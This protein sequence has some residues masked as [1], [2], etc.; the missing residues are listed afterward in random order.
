M[1]A[2]LQDIVTPRYDADQVLPPLLQPG[3]DAAT[4]IY[5]GTMVMVK[6]NGYAAPAAAGVAGS[7]GSVIGICN[8]QKINTT[9]AGYGSAGAL[10]VE[11]DR[12]AFW[13]NLNADS[14]VTIANFGA[15]V[16]A[17]DDNTVSLSDG[18][19]TRPLAGYLLSIPTT[20]GIPGL[21]NGTA[22]LKVAVQ[23]GMPSPWAAVSEQQSLSTLGKA[24]AVV[25]AIDAY[26]GS[27]TNVLTETTASSGFGTQDGVTV[28]VGDIVFLQ[29]GTANL[30][31]AKDSGPWQITT[32]GSASV[33]WVL[34]RP[35]WFS[36]GATVPPGYV[37]ELGGE[38][39]M[40]GGTSWK[41]FAAVGSAVVGTN[42]PEFYVGRVTQEVTLSSGVGHLSQTGAHSNNVGIYSATASQVVVT[43]TGTGGTTGT[44]SYGLGAALTPGYIG[45]SVATLWAFATAMAHNTSGE[46]GVLLAT[47]INW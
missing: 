45:T 19:G 30:S 35:D 11:V 8:K 18:G 34:T 43:Y 24:R 25:T 41:S 44:V 26:G 40:W 22:S 9:A 37:I 17:S 10:Q 27:G 3:V 14:T 36:T 32:L 7:L 12:G 13:L 16:Y 6:S 23:V 28:A 46:A 4:T 5:G 2:A 33:K 38:G 1:T 31:A 39:T 21:V 15:N 42:D 20:P 47:V 29:G